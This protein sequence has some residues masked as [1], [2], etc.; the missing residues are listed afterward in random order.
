MFYI[1]PVLTTNNLGLSSSY[2]LD[3]VGIYKITNNTLL[4]SINQLRSQMS[5]RW[6]NQLLRRVILQAQDVYCNQSKIY[7]DIEM[8]NINKLNYLDIEHCLFQIFSDFVPNHQ[9]LSQ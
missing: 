7:H 4:N 6:D 5:N 2:F 3:D 8:I 9:L 1:C